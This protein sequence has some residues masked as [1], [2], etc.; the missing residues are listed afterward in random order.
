MERIGLSAVTA[1]G[2]GIT[3]SFHTVLSLAVA[4]TRAGVVF[5]KMVKIGD[6][7]CLSK[8]AQS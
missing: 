8:G 4:G 7:D 5:V 6:L 3:P 2:T 1:P